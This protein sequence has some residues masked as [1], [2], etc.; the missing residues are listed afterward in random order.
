MIARAMTAHVDYT[1]AVRRDEDGMLWAHVRELEGCFASGATFDE[2][3]EALE[4]AVA[5]YL[6]P[7][8]APPGEA[9]SAHVATLGVA[10]EHLQAA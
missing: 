9:A 2:L 1:V 7:S 4:E 10:V 5:L 3:I 6:T 8:G